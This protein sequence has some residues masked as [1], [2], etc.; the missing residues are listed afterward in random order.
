M[1]AFVEIKKW[2]TILFIFLFLLAWGATAAAQEISDRQRTDLSGQFAGPWIPPGQVR[3]G[4]SSDVFAEG[5]GANSMLMLSASGLY[6]N[7]STVYTLTSQIG[8][9]TTQSSYEIIWYLSASKADGSALWKLALPGTPAMAPVFAPDGKIL[10]VGY[11]KSSLLSGNISSTEIFSGAA[12][13]KNSLFIITP[14]TPPLLKEVSI[15][16]MNISE[17]VSGGGVTI[18]GFPSY[19]IYLLC[20]LTS[21]EK[22][23]ENTGFPAIHFPT[24]KDYL[25]VMDNQGTILSRRELP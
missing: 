20:R 23:G 8:S 6:F 7:N 2:N 25:V 11:P 14:G 4:A 15:E 22:A 16:G 12:W 24:F 17:V 3:S 10:M 1:A 13:L 18:L 21:F 19:N 5:V 9:S